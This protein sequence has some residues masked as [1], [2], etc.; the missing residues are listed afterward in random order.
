MRWARMAAVVDLSLPTSRWPQLS[1]TNNTQPIPPNHC[2]QKLARLK[3][4]SSQPTI[5]ALGA[6]SGKISDKLILM[7]QARDKENPDASF[8]IVPREVLADS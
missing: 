2:I 8:S 1:T 6:G 7:P 4:Y 3:L 5:S